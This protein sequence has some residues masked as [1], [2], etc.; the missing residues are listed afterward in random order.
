ML[1]ESSF[2]SLNLLLVEDQNESAPLP[3]VSTPVAAKIC[4][5]VIPDPSA[6]QVLPPPA[7]F[8][9]A[10]ETVKFTGEFMQV[11]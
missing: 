7:P 1:M 3:E 10:V 6:A 4:P 11:F 9:A 5:S 8:G 2:M